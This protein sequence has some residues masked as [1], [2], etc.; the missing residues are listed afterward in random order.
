MSPDFKVDETYKMTEAGHITQLSWVLGMAVKNDI[1]TDSAKRTQYLNISEQLLS[2]FMKRGFSPRGIVYDAFDRTT[3]KAWLDSSGQATSAWWSNLE[4]VIAYAFAMKSDVFTSEQKDRI[5]SILNFL[6][7]SYFEYFADPIHGGE[8]FRVNADT[9]KVVD[10][11]KGNPG[12]S[13]YHVTEVYEYLFG[14]G[15]LGR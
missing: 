13:G 4:A 9:G 2:K 5:E 12:K 8:F 7:A 6:S 1:V 11:T 10:D 3:G 15:G 14:K